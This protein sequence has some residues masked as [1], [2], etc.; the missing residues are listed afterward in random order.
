VQSLA[1]SRVGIRIHAKTQELKRYQVTRDLNREMKILFD[2]NHIGIPFNQL[3]VH[4]E[5]EKDKE[6]KK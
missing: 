6:D 5:N 2:E 3:V 4:V 1:D